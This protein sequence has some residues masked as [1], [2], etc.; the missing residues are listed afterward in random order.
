MWLIRP[1]L[2]IPLVAVVAALSTTPVYAHGV[3]DRYDLP[4]PLS[5]FAAGGAAAVALSFVIVGLVVRSDSRVVGY[6]AIERISLF[7]D[8]V[9]F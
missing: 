9:G 6:P 8:P 1:R 7:V 4:L 2:W 3:G 5:Y